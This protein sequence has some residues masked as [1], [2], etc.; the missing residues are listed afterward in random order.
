MKLIGVYKTNIRTL[1]EFHLSK[2]VMPEASERSDSR[3]WADQ[4]YW[5]LSFRRHIKVRR[6]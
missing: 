6:A 4:Y 3:A 5:C 1:L 2:P